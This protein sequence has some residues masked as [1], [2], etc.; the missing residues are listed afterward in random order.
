MPAEL[1]LRPSSDAVRFVVLEIHP[2]IRITTQIQGSAKSREV[3]RN[4]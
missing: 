3:I 4:T 2:R 1:Q